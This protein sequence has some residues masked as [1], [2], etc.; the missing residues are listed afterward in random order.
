MPSKTNK[1]LQD[2]LH[3]GFCFLLKA[4]LG[5]GYLPPVLHVQKLRSSQL[6]QLAHRYTTSRWQSQ[7]CVPG[8]SGPTLPFHQS[9]PWPLGHALQFLNASKNSELILYVGTH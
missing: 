2:D 7:D 8:P 1:T 3:N 9:T 5:H 6:N 4:N